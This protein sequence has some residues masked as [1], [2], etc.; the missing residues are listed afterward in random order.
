MSISAYYN[1]ISKYNALKVRLF[2][3]INSFIYEM[4]LQVRDKMFDLL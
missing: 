1:E 4:I 2:A 3:I